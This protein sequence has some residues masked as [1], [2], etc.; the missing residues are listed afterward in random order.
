MTGRKLSVLF[1]DDEI[2]LLNGL[3][4]MLR[5]LRDEWDMT[6]VTS[7]QEAVE[8]LAQHPVDVVVTDMQMPQMDGAQLLTHVREHHPGTVRIILSGFV[9]EEAAIRTLSPSHQYLSKPCE[10][11]A[12]VTAVNQSL[13]LRRTLNNPSIQSA[14]GG[15]ACLPV[16]SSVFAE[17]LSE[18]D[19]AAAS[20]QSL[21]S[22]IERDPSLS[23][24]LLKLTNSAYFALPIKVV[25]VQTAISLLGFEVI[26]RVFLVS[27]I[28]ARFAGK[29]EMGAV[30]ERVSSRSFRNA[31]VARQ[32]ARMAGMSE[33]AADE[34][35]CTTLLCDV[36]TIVLA[37]HDFESVKKVASLV[38]T[39]VP[40]LEAECGVFGSNHALVGA[41]LLALWGFTDTIVEAVAFHHTPSLAG[42]TTCGP[43]A[44]A[45]IA[46][47][48]EG[49]SDDPAILWPFIL[50]DGP[51]PALDQPF[52]EA[53]GLG[54]ETAFWARAFRSAPDR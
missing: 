13:R 31:L 22:K 47:A 27:G 21:A 11:K 14:V 48:L 53:V 38:K 15:V 44:I 50:G 32:V 24:Q 6:F 10:P 7:A 33:K 29:P 8:R 3:R 23:A 34:A 42:T 17:V 19:N 12:L 43:L 4:R 52:L 41:Y 35:A 1:V 30:L 16:P 40:I 39:G 54:R 28:F 46:S 5:D 51:D 36:G 20:V 37:C 26:K 25:S 18:L 2:N 9:K 45:H 49:V